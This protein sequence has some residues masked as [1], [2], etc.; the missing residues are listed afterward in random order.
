MKLTTLFSTLAIT[1][2]MTGCVV[3]ASPTSRADFHQHK[4]LSL[5]AES[6]TAMDINAG[7]GFMVVEGKEGLSEIKVTADIYTDRRRAD[8][9]ELTLVK[10]GKTGVLVAKN[11]NT[12]G[13]WSGSSPRIDLVIHVPR[14]MKLDIDDG[15]G[16][17]DVKNING[18]VAINDGSGEISVENIVGNLSVHDGSGAIYIDSINGALAVVDGSGEINIENIEGDVTID[19]GSGT[20]YAKKINGSAE[21]DDG[22]GDLTVKQ[23]TG[24]V[25]VED[26]SGSI[27]IDDAGGLK[28]LDSGSGG[29]KVN[30]VRGDFTIDS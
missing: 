21:I 6:L 1:T 11:Y 17:M 10:Q 19:D 24:V 20:I 7:S 30:N 16:S 4:E 27:N 22:S 2:M 8:D 18:E 23:V 9:Y 26:G 15:S 29:L 5:S 3:I 13:F 14:S 12:S 25:T 28:I